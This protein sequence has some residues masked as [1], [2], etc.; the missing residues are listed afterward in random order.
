M[1]DDEAE[2]SRLIVNRCRPLTIERLPRV[3]GKAGIVPPPK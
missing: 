2:V 1:I 3:V